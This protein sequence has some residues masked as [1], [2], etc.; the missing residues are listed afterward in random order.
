M[1]TGKYGEPHDLQ[2]MRFNSPITTVVVATH[3][4]L[5]RAK[6]EDAYAVSRDGRTVV[7]ADGMGGHEGGEKA[8]RLTVAEISSAR[9]GHYIDRLRF[10]IRAAQASVRSMNAPLVEEYRRKDKGLPGA[11]VA[12]V[13]IAPDATSFAYG[14]AGDVRVW[15][16]DQIGVEHVT[17]DHAI[18]GALVKCIGG[19]EPAIENPGEYGDRLWRSDQR[20]V[21]SSDGLHSYVDEDDIAEALRDPSREVAL[22]RLFGL[23]VQATAPDNITIALVSATTRGV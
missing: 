13:R 9:E 2:V 21:L 4:G 12:A 8:S 20:L 10:G 16:T 17:R 23:A 15:L 3:A 18:G 22:R 14:W 6:N 5:K 19:V 1:N 7:V 11:A